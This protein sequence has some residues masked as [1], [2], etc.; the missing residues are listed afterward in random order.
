MTDRKHKRVVIRKDTWVKITYKL[1]KRWK[2]QVWRKSKKTPEVLQKLEDAYRVNCTDEEA[3]AN[4]WISE[5]TLNNWKAEDEKFLEQIR[6]WKKSYVY[7]IKKASFERAINTKNRDSTDILFKI[8]KSYSDKKDIDFKGQIS[9]VD[10]AR[11][12]QQKRLDKEKENGDT[13]N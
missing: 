7:E 13:E 5:S 6:Q 11:E 9:L 4:A 3:C 8:D 1:D 10:I 2:T 12:M